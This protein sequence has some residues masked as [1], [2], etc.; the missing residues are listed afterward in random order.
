M[1]AN[2]ETSHRK[3]FTP[4]DE[5]ETDDVVV[6]GGVGFVVWTENSMPLTR[7]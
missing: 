3:N 1:I 5:G 2:L 7:H 6:V 4:C